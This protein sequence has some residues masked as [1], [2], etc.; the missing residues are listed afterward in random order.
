MSQ[1]P[2]Y[3]HNLRD[4]QFNLF[5]FLDIGRTSLGKKPFGDL[6]EA[7]ARQTLETLAPI[8]VDALGASFFEGDHTPLV[9]DKEKGEVH[10]P[11]GIKRSF[12]TYY[13]A[14]MNALDLPT[15]L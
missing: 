15:H 5:E 12:G 13:E 8:C 2:H 3:K 11:A 10:L 6:D 4:I 14:G 7:S 1:A 9:L